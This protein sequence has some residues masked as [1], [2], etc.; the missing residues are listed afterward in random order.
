MIENKQERKKFTHKQ[1][2][3]VD[4]RIKLITES[5]YGI[6]IFIDIFIY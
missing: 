4:E 6:V 1:I 2:S 3:G 5:S